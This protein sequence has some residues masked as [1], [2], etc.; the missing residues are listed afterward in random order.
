MKERKT[1]VVL[2]T[3]AIF[4]AT[5]MT[6]IEGTIV[7][8]AMPTIVSSLQGLAIMNWV[9]SIYLLT[10]AMVTPIYG[11]LADQIGRKPVFLSGILIFIIGSALSGLSQNMI[12][13]ILF[14]AIQGIG[15]GAIMPI[16][17]TII[18][19]IY[20]IEKRAKVL[21]LNN[22]AWGIASIV[23]PLCGG[24]IVDLFSWHWIFLINVPIGLI[25]MGLLW[26][27]LNEDPSRFHSRAAIDWSGTVTLMLFL[28]FLL[29]GFQ[30]LGETEGFSTVMLICFILAAVF[31]VLFIRIEKHAKNPIISLELFHNSTFIIVSM[32]ATFING[33]LIGVEVY[34]PMWIQGILGKS[35]ALGGLVLAPMSITWILGS[36]LS[37]RLNQKYT[38]KTVLNIGIL[39]VLL[40]GSCLW[41]V[42]EKTAYTIFLGIAVLLG[43]GFGLVITS[44]MVEAQRCVDSSMVGV[45]TSFTTLVRTVGQ[46]I[47]IAIFGVIVNQSLNQLLVAERKTGVTEALMNKLINAEEIRHIPER[48]I[49]TL[50]TILYHNLHSVYFAGFFLILAAF[51]INWF[52][53]KTVTK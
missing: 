53:K 30:K 49:P 25:V 43:V 41:L 15:A 45:A 8:T 50:R 1:N 34:M 48:L 40:G 5:F 6:A 51:V 17:L 2:V 38:I 18:A 4:I 44:S 20:P 13:L 21:G 11:K 32:V 24:F 35:A 7:T 23:G 37:S 31:L 29:Y 16:S 10:N 3:I 19:D 9:F 46:T 42:P 36:F 27:F 33:F 12:Q 26:R 47:M 39:F 28:L 14:R 52:Q 22:A